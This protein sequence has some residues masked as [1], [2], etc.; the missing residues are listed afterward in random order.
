[1]DEEYEDSAAGID[2]SSYTSEGLYA[3]RNDC[4]GLTELDVLNSRASGDVVG[5]TPVYSSGTGKGEHN[6]KQLSSQ[7]SNDW[8]HGWSSDYSID[9]DLASICED[10][11]RVT[12]G[13]QVAESAVM[14][15]ESQTKTLQNMSAE[16]YSETQHLSQQLAMELS[17]GEKL[18]REI[19]ILRS[20][21]WKFKN[22]LD[23]LK[24]ASASQHT[25]RRKTPSVQMKCFPEEPLS[26]NTLADN[27]LDAKQSNLSCLFHSKLLH[28]IFLIEC[29]AQ[30]IQTKACF[31]YNGNE[32]DH[33][34]S[35]FN[36]LSS[37]IQNLK[38]TIA[39]ELSVETVCG[40]QINNDQYT[41]ISP[42]EQHIQGQDAVRFFDDFHYSEGMFLCLN[43]HQVFFLV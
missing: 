13:V 17:S 15:L 24:A 36:V 3:E 18:A 35:E 22:D 40:I 19:N 10:R 26:G 21:Y 28:E 41:S 38:Q 32:S 7:L 25:S 33:I 8:S 6:Y 29:K 42:S 39:R 34:Y 14:Q 27:T 1:M 23:E 11:D 16:L 43:D 12:E 4:S 20:E 2:G 5:C 30:Q 31:G 37:L 9:N